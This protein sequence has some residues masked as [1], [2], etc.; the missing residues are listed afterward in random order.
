MKRGVH[1]SAPLVVALLPAVVLG[2]GCGDGPASPP[3]A[4][5]HDHTRELAAVR[6]FLSSAD[7]R[8]RQLTESLVDHD[9]G[10]A[11]LRL[12]HYATP[13]GRWESLEV[14]NP[15]T[16]PLRRDDIG[17][18]AD[19]PYRRTA[20]TD[21]PVVSAAEL[22]RRPADW[23]HDE[24]LDLG[25]RAFWTYPL[26]VDM[27]TGATTDSRASLERY[28]LWIDERRDRVGGLVRVRL[29]HEREGFAKT[30]A[31]CHAS[32]ASRPSRPTDAAS[33]RPEVVA[34]RANADFDRGA[35]LARRHTGLPAA[36]W[37]PGRI[38]VTPDGLDNP[39][40]IPDLRPLRYQSHLHAAATLRNSLPALAV[41]IDTLLITS[42]NRQFRPP[43]IV[44]AA[45]AYYLWH[46]SSPEADRSAAPAGSP[47]DGSLTD[48]GRDLFDQHC[49]HCHHPDGTTA[50]PVL[51]ERVGTDRTAGDSPTRGTGRY[52]IPS[53]RGV[54]HRAQYLHTGAFR[55][56]EA[57]FD[58][59][60]LDEHPGHRWGTDLP[61]QDRR[62]LLSYLRRLRPASGP[63]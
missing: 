36:D 23:S 20:A 40:A 26:Q 59:A 9:N 61:Q 15:P 30:C 58:P 8:R 62:A 31:T 53:L 32:H 14:W 3:S 56:L 21:Q 4:T 5:G 49:D 63:P 38:D 52:R 45:L 17:A 24:L 34:G 54:A 29:P 27:L 51:I 12:R 28:G 55:S 39:T 1:I 16:R 10:Y 57:M 47:T 46:L 2:L 43:R 13:D 41:R 19:A 25:R 42:L 48:R 50:A 37:G 33:D 18:F 7:L 22:A 11:R 60:R 6:D 35:L 44:S